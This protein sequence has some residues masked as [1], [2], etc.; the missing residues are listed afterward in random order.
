M[1]TEPDRRAD[2]GAGRPLE[3]ERPARTAPRRLER[4]TRPAR[5]LHA[6][7]YLT[8]LVLLGT[9]WWL[10]LGNEGQPSVLAQVLR[11]ADTDAHKNAGWVLFAAGVLVPLLNAKAARRFLA[12][13]VRFDRGDL[14][15]LRRWP[16]AVLTGRFAHHRGHFDPGQ[17]LANL[18]IV[19]GLAILTLSG[20]G[21]VL[22]HGGPA[23]VWL[24]RIHRWS[25]YVLTPV[26]A[27]HILIALGVLPGYRGV[28]RS[29]HT[30][31]GV[32]ERTARRLW[33]AWT[34]TVLDERDR[35]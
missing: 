12:A 7:V 1:T 35:P 11:V 9:G 17:R 31:R 10:L 22:V 4:Y 8:T 18:V 2:A 3:G 6:A 21:L 16:A 26:I 28:W 29:M 15:W 25:T 19:L 30:R 13:S 23:F 24:T 33:P 5:W 27:G 32:D 14:G 34:R 20:I